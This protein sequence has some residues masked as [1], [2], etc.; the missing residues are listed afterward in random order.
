MPTLIFEGEEEP[1][2]FEA[3]PE[4]NLLAAAL[5]AGV[6]LGFTCKSG[7]CG[8]CKVKV[9]AGSNGLSKPTAPE[10]ALLGHDRLKRQWRLACQCRILGP[11]Q[12]ACRP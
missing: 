1:L 10:Q 2:R 4:T 6:P 5:A 7:R 11:V 3:A 9:L 8:A 12:F